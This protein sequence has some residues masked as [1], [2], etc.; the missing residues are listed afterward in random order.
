MVSGAGQVPASH[1][2]G[3]VVEVLSET[4]GISCIGCV[5]V[6]PSAVRHPGAERFAPGGD[7]FCV[8]D[9]AN[10]HNRTRAGTVVAGAGRVFLSLMLVARLAP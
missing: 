3:S 8:Y 2:I 7:T 5:M 10:I 1:R 4:P 9:N 6:D